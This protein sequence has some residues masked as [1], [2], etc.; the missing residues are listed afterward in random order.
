MR[1]SDGIVIAGGGLAAQKCAETLR[2]RGYDGPI[3]MVCAE[4]VRPYDRPPLSKE[5]LTG[6]VDPSLR[7]ADWYADNEVELLLGTTATG[8]VG[9]YLETTNGAL[10]FDQLLIATGASA[11]RLPFGSVLRSVADA[12]DLRTRLR[13]GSRLAVVGAG[14]VGMEVAASARSLGVDVVLIDVA[15]APLA[16]LLGP[17]V[18]RWLVGLHR[19]EG[20]EVV[21]GEGVAAARRGALELV[22][23][24]RVP[25]DHVLVG[26][27][28]VPGP[29][30]QADRPDIFLA[31]DVTGTQHWDAAVR[32]AQAAARA[33]LGLDAPPPALPSFW[34]DQYGLR[35]Q[36]VGDASRADSVSWDG[37]PDA[38][39]FTAVYS[40]EGRPVAGLVVDRPRELPKLRR[41]I[42]ENQEVLS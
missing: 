25:C 23:G 20:V 30:W 24:R 39:D 32:Q 36:Y 5:A 3:R 35:I 15:P 22:G 13:P 11:R 17:D 40:R 21:L 14:F 1:G 19:A 12:R 7:P 8:V 27:G 10:R 34:S 2:S 38:R 18:S 42:T 41:L 29:A 33:M 37:S 26:I 4:P 16:G 28:V 9:R 31:G 6:E